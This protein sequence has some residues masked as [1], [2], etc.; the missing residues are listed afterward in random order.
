MNKKI[1]QKKLD[2]I[3][4][5]VANG[6][7]QKAVDEVQALATTIDDKEYKEWIRLVGFNFNNNKKYEISSTEHT[8]EAKVAQSILGLI[9]ELRKELKKTVQLKDDLPKKSK[10]TLQVINLKTYDK[11]SVA[12]FGHRGFFTD[13]N[14]KEITDLIRHGSIQLK[15]LLLDLHDVTLRDKLQAHSQKPH[16][17]L[18]SFVEE[19]EFVKELQN[20]PKKGSKIEVKTT[21]WFPSLSI[22][23]LESKASKSVLIEKH[24]LSFSLYTDMTLRYSF[25]DKK[26]KNEF[27]FYFQGFEKLWS[28]GSKNWNGQIPIL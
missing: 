24:S 1:L 10:S 6:R 25:D 8:H 4:D 7:L 27:D 5:F 17:A 11:L 28:L 9:E 22:A 13:T 26:N 21:N 3:C 14:Y 2:E 12:S 15:Y 23:L 16:M 18:T 19:Y 20:L